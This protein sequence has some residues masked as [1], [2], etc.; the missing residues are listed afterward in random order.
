VYGKHLHIA[1][2][3]AFLSLFS[4]SIRAQESLGLFNSLKGFGAAARFQER[5]GIFHSAY[6]YIDIYG[7]A[8]GRCS[9][10]GIRFN[11][12]RQYVLGRKDLGD[13][14]LTFYAGPGITAGYVRDHDKGRGVDLESLMADN[15]GIMAALS[16]DAGCRFDFNG[17]VAL[18]LSLEGDLGVH[19]RR[20]EKEEGYFAPSLSIF[21]NGW[22]QVLYPQ[23]TILFKL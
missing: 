3:V 12:S 5:D 9:N 11:V 20:N 19:I 13:V 16:A 23:F 15:D 2:L 22:M 14:D 10:P 4:L 8:T 6:A 17:R 7:V 21:N 1:L 18:D